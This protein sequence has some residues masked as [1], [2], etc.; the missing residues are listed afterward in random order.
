MNR[1]LAGAAGAALLSIGGFVSPALAQAPRPAPLPTFTWTG[2]YVG[3]TAGFLQQDAKSRATGSNT[4]DSSGLTAATLYANGV[5]Q[6]INGPLAV[7]QGGT[8]GGQ[9]GYNYQIGAAVIGV[10][11]DVQTMVTGRTDSRLTS[12]PITGFPDVVQTS[13][14]SRAHYDYFGTVRGRI[15]YLL[16]DSLLVY[17]TG[18]FAYGDLHRL[19][20]IT[21]GINVLPPTTFVITG[22]GTTIRSSST[23]TGYTAGGGFE[24]ALDA[25]WSVKG[26]AL[27][28][29]LGRTSGAGQFSSFSSF[30]TPPTRFTGNAVSL[31]TDNTGYLARIGLNY[32]FN[33]F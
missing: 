14:S 19:I 26:E 8:V 23:P 30:F 32:K 33:L 18:G 5:A 13:V 15:G 29:D 2:F 12:T 3:A 21:N 10:E 6:A 25:S 24:Y 1:L 4:F 20:T 27:Y 22:F 31:R 9:I 7:P 17:G 16:T 11:A 28:Y